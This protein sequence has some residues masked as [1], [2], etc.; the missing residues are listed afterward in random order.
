ML[1]WLAWVVFRFD[2]KPVA[3]LGEG[4]GSEGLSEDWGEKKYTKNIHCT[5]ARGD[6]CNLLDAYLAHSVDERCKHLTGPR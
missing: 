3:G 5:H 4:N 2:P 1:Q 6:P